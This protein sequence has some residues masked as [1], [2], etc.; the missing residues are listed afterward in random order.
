M[1]YTSFYTIMFIID[2]VVPFMNILKTGL[3]TLFHSCTNILTL[4]RYVI[5]FYTRPRLLIKTAD[6]FFKKY[7]QY[8]VM[9]FY[10]I[11]SLYLCSPML[12][13]NQEHEMLRN[14]YLKS[15]SFLK[16]FCSSTIIFN[17]SQ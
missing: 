3:A 2:I 5:T 9:T 1:I 17:F 10:K 13:Y 4:C 12:C 11:I 6:G 15:S 8:Y 14:L 7:H 16:P